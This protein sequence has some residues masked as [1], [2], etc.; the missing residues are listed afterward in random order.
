MTKQS[1]IHTCHLW[2]SIAVVTPAAFIYAFKPDLFL[3]LS[4]D[5]IDEYSFYKALAGLYLSFS[6][7]WFYGLFKPEL[8]KPVLFSN[9][10]FM[11]GLGLGRTFSVLSDGFPSLLYVLGTIG[12]LVLGVYGLWVLRIKL[13]EQVAIEQ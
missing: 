6:L 1:F 3:E 9:T 8:I 2:I 10:V 5:S 4:P 11:L 12:E 13:G 7:F